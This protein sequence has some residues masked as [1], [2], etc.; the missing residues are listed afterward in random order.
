MENFCNEAEVILKLEIDKDDTEGL[1]K[2]LGILNT[3]NEKQHIYDEMFEPLKAI[4]DLLKEYEYKFSDNV[5]AQV[6]FLFTF[7]WRHNDID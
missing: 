3:I 5:L 7:I 4:V 1:L 2:I 6:S